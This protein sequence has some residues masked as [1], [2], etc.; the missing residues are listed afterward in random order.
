[1]VGKSCGG[2]TNLKFE[3]VI[4]N[5]IDLLGEQERKDFR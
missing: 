4:L 5:Y 2:L 1:M 3:E